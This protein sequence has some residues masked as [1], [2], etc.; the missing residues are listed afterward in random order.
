MVIETSKRL[1]ALAVLATLFP[2]A[3]AVAEPIDGTNATKAFNSEIALVASDESADTGI[4]LVGVFSAYNADPRQTD[5][6]P[7]IM[8][9]NKTIYEGAIACPRKYRFGTQVEINGKFYTCEDRMNI[10]YE[11]KEYEHFDILMSSYTA[12]KNFGRQKLEITVYPV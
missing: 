3:V 9:S 5:S 2:V 4:K 8:A 1:L 12:A 11:N 10:R 7:T 6:T